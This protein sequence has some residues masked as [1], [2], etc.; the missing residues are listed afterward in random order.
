MWRVAILL[1]WA[2]LRFRLIMRSAK[3]TLVS[4]G[5]VAALT[6]F[7][8]DFQRGSDRRS[9]KFLLLRSMTRA[10]KYALTSVVVQ[11]MR[12]IA[13]A[14]MEMKVEQDGEGKTRITIWQPSWMRGA[15]SIDDGVHWM[16]YN[17]REKKIE[18]QQSPRITQG[19]PAYQIALADE[20]YKWKLEKTA[21]IADRPTVCVIA[22]PNAK[23][24]E[25]RRYYLDERSSVMLRQEV[26]ASDNTKVLLFDTRAIAYLSPA[27]RLSI[28]ADADKGYRVVNVEAPERISPPSSARKRVSF[29]P[30]IPDRLPYGFVV[31][32]VE[33]VGRR[34]KQFLALRISDGLAIATIY[35]WNAKITPWRTPRGYKSGYKESKGVR[36]QLMGD[37]P[38]K[39]ASKIVAAFL[40]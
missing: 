26:V 25:T 10:H 36:F 27:T 14:E 22:V 13:N 16:T 38:S 1:E 12:H 5:L 3:V 8:F 20:N 30:V 33:L 40:K 28:D 2:R 6:S 23:E 11:K 35:Q 37:I 7:S 4:I 18:R 31:K 9:P 32:D 34:G 15:I 39:A 17:A 24:L 29:I 19:N 21:D